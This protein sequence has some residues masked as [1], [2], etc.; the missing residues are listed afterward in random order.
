MHPFCRCSTAP[1]VDREA[2]EKSLKKEGYKNGERF[3]SSY[4]ISDRFLETA[5]GSKEEIL[6]LYQNDAQFK[7]DYDAVK[8]H[9][10]DA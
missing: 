5:Y 2:F 3:I 7:E 8:W 1:Y 4:K 10:I 6:H 9:W